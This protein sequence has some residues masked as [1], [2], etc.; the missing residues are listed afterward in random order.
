MSSGLQI[1]LAAP[2]DAAALAH[3][4]YRGVVEGA[5][6]AYSVEE[7]K[8]WAPK[9]PDTDTFAKRLSGMITLVAETGGA[10]QGFMSL[11]PDGYLDFT[12]VLPEARGTGVADA[13]YD[14]VLSEVQKLGLNHMASEA[15]HLARSFLTRHGWQVDGEQDVDINGVTLRNFKMSID[16][17]T[18]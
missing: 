7:R 15:S 5:A 16:L 10:I 17:S 18:Q 6:P 11:R 13:L 3:V 1:R 9:Q 4:F 14:A 8:A 12:Y 2:D